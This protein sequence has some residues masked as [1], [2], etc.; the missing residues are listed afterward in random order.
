MSSIVHNELLLFDS[1]F[2]KLDDFKGINYKI[3]ENH[4]YY[5]CGA[6]FSFKEICKILE[7]EVMSLPADRRGVSMYEDNEV[8]LNTDSKKKLRVNYEQVLFYLFRF[9]DS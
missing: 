5:D 4:K 8:N 1:D 3:E 9:V 2:Q 6:H 7:N